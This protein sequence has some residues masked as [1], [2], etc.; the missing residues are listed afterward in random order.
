[1]DERD[2]LQ[3]VT[4]KRP[5]QS[6]PAPPAAKEEQS[7]ATKVYLTKRLMKDGR[8]RTLEEVAAWIDC[9]EAGA[10]AR[11]RD[12]RK[13]KYGAGTVDKRLR[14]DDGRVWEYRYIPR[15]S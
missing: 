3:L 14:N 5:A 2:L 13:K 15:K 9:S 11:L 1:M 12:L 10:S 7:R 6:A 4:A 8:W